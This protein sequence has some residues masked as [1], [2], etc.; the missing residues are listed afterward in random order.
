MPGLA[1]CNITNTASAVA[2]G[3]CCLKINENTTTQDI[4][5]YHIPV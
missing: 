5:V 3:F 4:S 2:I 1:E